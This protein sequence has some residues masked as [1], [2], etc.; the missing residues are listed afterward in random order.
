MK[1]T[2]S[3]EWLCDLV[4]DLDQQS[5]EDIGLA[6]TALGAETEDISILNYGKN[7]ELGEVVQLK[8]LLKNNIVTIKTNTKT[9]QTISNSTQ[10]SVGDFV[11]FAPVGSLIFGD[12]KVTAREIDEIKTDG[13]LIALE[14]LGIE[15]KSN[16]IIILGKNKTIAES[17]YNTYI[18]VDAIYTL[19]VPGNRADWLSVRGLARALSIYFHLELKNIPKIISNSNEIDIEISIESERC[20]RYA[21]RK[22]SNIQN[23]SSSPLFQKRLLL[24]GMRPIDYIV[25]LTNIVMLETGQPTHAFDADHITDNIIVRQA[26][27]GEVLT[28]LD[29]KEII[30]SDDDLVICSGEKILAL[31]G[32]MGGLHSGV[33]AKTTSIYLESASFNGVWIRRSAKRL[34]LKTESSLRFEKNITAELVPQASEYIAYHYKNADISPLKELYPI[35]V[36]RYEI[37]CT[38]DD[39]RKYLGVHQ[40]DDAFMANI[41]TK[42]GCELQ[43]QSHHWTIIPSGERNDLCIKEDIIEEIARFYGYDHIPAS[44]YRPSGIFLNPNKSFDEKIRPLLRG[45]GLNEAVTVVFRSPDTRSFYNINSSEIVPILNPLNTEWTELRTHL[46]DGLLSVLRLNTSKAF[47]KNLSFSE[48]ANVFKKTSSTGEFIEEKKL[49]FIVSNEKNP[50]EKGLNILQ[51]ILKYAKVS[52]ISAVRVH[53]KFSF[54]HP[55]NAFELMCDGKSIGF[56]GEI[57]PELHQKCDLSDNKQFPSPVVCEIL[58]EVLKNSSEEKKHLQPINELPPIMRDITL[59]INEEMLGLNLEQMMKNKNKNLKEVSFVSVFQDQKLKDLGKK[60]LSLRLRFEP[61]EGLDAKDI[62][63]FIHELLE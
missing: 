7:I 50:Y 31:A 8:T 29:E 62:D 56:F 39:I 4:Q 17:Y 60:N 34:G 25:D 51:N 11:M 30:L 35:T 19:D 52:H 3:Y 41:I 33:S 42:I 38:P 23:T 20:N 26:K 22:I 45:M 58:F 5:P 54:L 59:S 55:L 48:I 9:Y 24:L 13:L 63:K 10:L 15:K 46:F 6:L 28:L 18:A 47:E 61:S 21:I 36:P 1:M 44:V 53:H 14:N 32:I 16:D 37:K 2:V 12:K 40:I 57:H 49:A 43:T 27:N